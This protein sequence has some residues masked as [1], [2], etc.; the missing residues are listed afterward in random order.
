MLPVSEN[1][2]FFDPSSRVLYFFIFPDLK[3]YI[4]GIAEGA[5]WNFD[6]MLNDDAP[7]QSTLITAFDSE[8][9]LWFRMRDPRVGV[10]QELVIGFTVLS[11]KFGLGENEQAKMVNIS[12]RISKDFIYRAKTAV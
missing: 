6:I 5:Q 4:G 8:T 7:E 12:G 3:V 10:T 11:N 2:L 1:P 9:P